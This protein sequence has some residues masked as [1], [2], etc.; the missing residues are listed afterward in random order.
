MTGS[1]LMKLGGHQ[2]LEMNSALSNTLG[3]DCGLFEAVS[4]HMPGRIEENHEQSA[5]RD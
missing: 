1:F 2:D 3:S 4:Q 5:E